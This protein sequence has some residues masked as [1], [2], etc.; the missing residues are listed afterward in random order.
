MEEME[1][2]VSWLS[3]FRNMWAD[4]LKVFDG[5]DPYQRSQLIPAREDVF[6]DRER[7]YNNRAGELL[8]GTNFFGHGNLAV[9][10]DRNRPA[11]QSL[12]LFAYD[13]R[14]VCSNGRSHIWDAD[15]DLNTD[16][17]DK[18]EDDFE[19]EGDVDEDDDAEGFRNEDGGDTEGDDEFMDGPSHKRS[20]LTIEV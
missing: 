8:R 20:R 11:T 1:D 17:E 3:E 14:P 13:A 5:L 2:I 19:E 15:Y 10:I 4:N 12:D 7:P 9:A 18:E 6:N 16:G